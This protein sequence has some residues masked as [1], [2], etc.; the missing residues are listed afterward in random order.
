MSDSGER[1][2]DSTHETLKR[3]A[4]E[5]LEPSRGRLGVVSGAGS[6]ADFERAGIRFG[7]L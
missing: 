2:L 7:R 6:Q 3:V 5:Y 4:D 1:V